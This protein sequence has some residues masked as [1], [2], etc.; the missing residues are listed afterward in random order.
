MAEHFNKLTPA[1]LELLAHAA[2][3]CAEVV[4][5]AM[6]IMRHGLLS[7]NNGQLELTNREHLAKELGQVL[8][9]IQ[10]L[11]DIGMVRD[12]ELE[13]AKNE[14]LRTIWVYLHHHKRPL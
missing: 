3:E 14:K 1:E 7:D 10:L 11:K 2:E 5:A 9:A 8:A 4:Y 6:K 13:A 12:S